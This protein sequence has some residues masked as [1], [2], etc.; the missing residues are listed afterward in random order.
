[1]NRLIYADAFMKEILLMKRLNAKYPLGTDDKEVN[2]YDVG[3]QETFDLIIKHLEEFSIA[4]DIDKV[5]EQLNNIKKYHLDLADTM[6]DVQKNGTTRHFICLED[7]IEIVKAGG[8]V[9]E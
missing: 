1:M 9:N 6:L 2:N 5:I 8:N 7:A 4:Y 3:Q